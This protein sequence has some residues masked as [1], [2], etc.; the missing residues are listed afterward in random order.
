MMPGTLAKWYE[1]DGGCDVR[2][3][4]KPGSIIYRLALDHLALDPGEVLAIGDSLEHD[5]LGAS[6]SGI[7]SLF[8]AGGIAS[9]EL[10]IQN[11]GAEATYDEEAVLRLCKDLKVPTPTYSIP[12][13][14]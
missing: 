13:L 10:H 12:Y 8:I 3:M 1:E 6:L 4:G 2:V 9:K 14:A 7:D 5:I 11:T